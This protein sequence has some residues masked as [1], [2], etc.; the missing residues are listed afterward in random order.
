MKE[1]LVIIPNPKLFEVTQKVTSFDRKLK[2]QIALMEQFLKSHEGAGLAANQI[3]Y[4]NRVIV[5]GF[6]DPQEKKNS[7]PFQVFINPEIVEYSE[8]KESLEE[9]CL[10][11]PQIELP[12]ERSLKIKFRGQNPLGKK[13]KLV[14]RGVLARI[15]QHET[16]HLNGIIFT[17]H[18]KEKFLGKNPNLKKLKIIF[19]GSGEFAAPI[20]KGLI[21]LGFNPLIITEK[22]KPAGREQKIK[23]TPVAEL[24]Q[25]FG[26]KIIEIENLKSDFR[27]PSF[28]F[29]AF[30][31]L[32]CADFGQK[33]PEE[34]LKLAKIAAINIHPSLLPKYRGAAP[35]PAMILEG[36]KETGVSIIRMTAEFDQGPIL[37]QI[38]TEVY[39][40]DN[41]LALE[42]RLATLGV[43]LLYE[44]IPL[45]AKRELREI[46]QDE[47]KA[48][49]AKKLQ[50]TDGEINWENPPEKIERQIRAF[51]PWPGSYTFLPDGKR[52]IIHRSHLAGEGLVLDLV[53]P[54]DGKS[55]KWAEFLRGFRGAKPSWFTKIK[56]V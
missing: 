30:D 38:K 24:A 32:I 45:L 41:S 9:G 37:A 11:L 18:V 49:W 10:S 29:R 48:T 8:E 28:D 13:I 12:V 36:E 46:A 25:L 43:K 6:E 53:Q 56:G 14:A 15:L 23:S 5:I 33:I 31:L 42:N 55:M 22:G 50:K 26:K 54:A 27:S 39:P 34:I 16:D 3:G 44:T 20:L 47:K 7:I 51:Y 35:I 1:Q 21:L 2:N 17:E 52:L 4:D 19:M 40:T